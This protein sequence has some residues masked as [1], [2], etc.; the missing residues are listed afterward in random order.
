MDI[1]SPVGFRDVDGFSC[2]PKGRVTDQFKGGVVK[3]EIVVVGSSLNS[4]LG[5]PSTPEPLF[6]DFALML[7]QVNDNVINLE[8]VANLLE[9]EWFFLKIPGKGVSFLVELGKYS[10]VGQC[11]IDVV[12]EEEICLFAYFLKV[13]NFPQ[14]VFSS[15]SFS[16]IL[17]QA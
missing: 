15:L 12:C 13:E 17:S 2:F 14:T 9:V 4:Q 1:W 11:G 10:K 7:S 5:M 16:M 8:R 3:C 6:F